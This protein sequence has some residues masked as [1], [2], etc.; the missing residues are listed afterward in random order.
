[1]FLNSILVVITDLAAG[2]LGNASFRRH[3]HLLLTAL[4]LFGPLL[5]LWVS[6][7]SVFAKRTHFLYR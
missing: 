3:F 4:L 2:L 6:H 1:M 5:S 7:Y